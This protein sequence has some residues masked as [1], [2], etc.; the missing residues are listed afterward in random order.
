M[1]VDVWW[2]TTPLLN[3]VQ[4]LNDYSQELIDHAK[5]LLTHALAENTVSS[6]SSHWRM[7]LK[8]CS[9]YKVDPFHP[10]QLQLILFICHESKRKLLTSTIEKRISTVKSIV[11][12]A[13]GPVDWDGFLH[14]KAIMR[15]HKR[16][17]G[18]SDTDS[19]L[20][21]TTR[22]LCNY[23]QKTKHGLDRQT[24]G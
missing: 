7:Y 4:D 3:K 22:D 20:P 5:E 9:K 15:G 1:I 23:F 10:S 11:T 24:S 17:S 14:M 13:A 18:G 8:F 19:R 12:A 21:I 6:Y 2:F 16:W